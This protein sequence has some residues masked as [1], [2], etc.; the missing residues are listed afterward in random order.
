[1]TDKEDQDL[2]PSKEQFGTYVEAEIAREKE[3][4]EQAAEPIEVPRA[5]KDVTIIATAFQNAAGYYKDLVRDAESPAM[6]W[7]AKGACEAYG[8]VAARIR[9][10]LD[11]TVRVKPELAE[12]AIE[13]TYKSNISVMRA[14]DTESRNNGILKEERNGQD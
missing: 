7:Y 8:F 5:V 6:R 14:L 11:P 3:L 4:Q 1:M 10:V 2:I 12:A 9:E 13:A